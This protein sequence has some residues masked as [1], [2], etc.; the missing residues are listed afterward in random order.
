MG[1]I[2][3]LAL[4]YEWCRSYR[5][6]RRG[7]RQGMGRTVRRDCDIRHGFGAWRGHR[8]A[9][10][11]TAWGGQGT[12]AD[13]D[14][15]GHACR[16]RGGGCGCHARKGTETGQIRVFRVRGISQYPLM[17]KNRFSGHLRGSAGAGMTA[18][19]RGI[20]ARFRTLA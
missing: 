17:R 11:M 3:V 2:A 20:T 6:R 12:G 18:R 1:G 4:R 8:D 9:W 10:D 19:G 16:R 7:E 5:M 15:H 13:H 14:A